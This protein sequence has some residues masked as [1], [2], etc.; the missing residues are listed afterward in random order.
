MEWRLFKVVWAFS[1]G[2]FGLLA[3]VRGTQ[4][5]SPR[6]GR[7][8]DCDLILEAAGRL[9]SADHQR[10]LG[11]KL[12]SLGKGL[13]KTCED[14]VCSHLFTRKTHTATHL[15]AGMEP[16]F[17]TLVRIGETFSSAPGDLLL[18]CENFIVGTLEPL[19]FQSFSA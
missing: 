6:L 13:V 10:F 14:A 17:D 16:L 2:V 9:G 3:A 15:G 5:P 7:G 18:L 19:K 12:S 4:G 8:G 1:T 11:L